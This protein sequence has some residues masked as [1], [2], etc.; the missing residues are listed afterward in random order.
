ML[1]P[2]VVQAQ[3]HFIVLAA[4]NEGEMETNKMT[5]HKKNT[6][7]TLL[8]MCNANETRQ[9]ERKRERERSINGSHIK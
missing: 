2:Q 7:T 5:A 3:V 1:E 9:G 4:G 6:Q 8:I